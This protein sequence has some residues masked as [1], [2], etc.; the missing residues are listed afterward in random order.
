LGLTRLDNALARLPSDVAADI[1]HHPFLLDAHAS[2]EGEDVREMLARKYG[3]DPD[4]AWDRLEA[5]AKKSGLDLNMRKQK[6][7]YATQGAEMLIQA[8]R[9]KGTQHRIAVAFS[10]AYYLDARNIADRAVLIEIATANGFTAEEAE[11]VLDDTVLRQ[12]IEAEAA[13]AAAQGVSGV[14]FF[15]F[16]GKF[17]LSGAQPEEVF[18]RALE[19]ALKPEDALQGS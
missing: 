3:R 7:R 13:A 4:E 16:S 18:D 12:R 11:A 2:E 9:Q 6:W 15:I 5:E 10:H 8:A 14:P 19:M 17:A 1:E